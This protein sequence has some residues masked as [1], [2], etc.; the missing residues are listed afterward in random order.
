VLLQSL[1]VLSIASQRPGRISKYIEALVRPTGVSRRFACVFLTDLHF[2]DALLSACSQLG[3][4]VREL[5]VSM[6]EW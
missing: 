3:Q 5:R 2:A 4:I 6:S 1:R